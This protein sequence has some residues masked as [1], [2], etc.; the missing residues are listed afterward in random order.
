[1]LF[2]AKPPVDADEWEWQLAA[3]KWL[4]REYPDL[5]AH[6]ILATPHGE[7]FPDPTC[8]GPDRGV[9]LFNQV[10]S[11]VGI[12]DWPTQLIPV[13]APKAGVAVNA[14]AAIQSEGGACGMFR[15]QQT[16]DGLW[17]GEISYTTEQLSNE[18]SLVA[19]F[20]HEAAH[21]L[22]AFAQNPRPGGDDIEELLTDL[23]AVWLGFG[24]FL[25]NHARYGHHT[26]DAGGTWY[27]SGSR[28]YLGERSLMTALAIS[29]ILAGRDPLAA[30]PYLK[31][32][33]VHDLRLA[34]R[35]ASKRD[36]AA[37]MAAINLEDFGA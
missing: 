33:L 15:L 26:S 14:V 13:S 24:T 20:A 37:E 3:F 9:E 22:L 25:G 16:P 29:E 28:G 4:E 30:E 18:Q 11:I 6:R 12:A 36:L 10:K 27:V 35:Y 8:A 5:V 23:T 31:P 32:Y 21:Y 2:R 17:I 34:A 19:T 1:M 7:A